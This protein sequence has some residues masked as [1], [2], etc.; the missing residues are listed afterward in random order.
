MCPARGL[1]K[2]IKCFNCEGTI[3]TSNVFKTG[4]EKIQKAHNNERIKGVLK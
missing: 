3:D 2:S 1:P 4:K